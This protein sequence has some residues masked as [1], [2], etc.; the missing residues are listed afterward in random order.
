MSSQRLVHSWR[1]VTTPSRDHP[2][3]LPPR[4][5]LA[6]AISIAQLLAKERAMLIVA[7]PT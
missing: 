3:A 5:L 6:L 2:M 7:S 4:L 1:S